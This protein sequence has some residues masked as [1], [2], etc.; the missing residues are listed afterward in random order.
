LNRTRHNTI[1]FSCFRLS[2]SPEFS[3]NADNSGY[4]ESKDG[5]GIV[6]NQLVGV[7]LPLSIHDTDLDNLLAATNSNETGKLDISGVPFS[8]IGNCEKILTNPI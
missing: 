5:F 8:E 4:D 1:P 7:N 3:N 2:T 6:R